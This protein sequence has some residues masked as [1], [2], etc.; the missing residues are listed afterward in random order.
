MRDRPSPGQRRLRAVRRPAHRRARAAVAAAPAAAAPP[1]R[2]GRWVR[3][4]GGRGGGGRGAQLPRR[5]LGGSERSAGGSAGLRGARLRPWRREAAPRRGAGH[6]RGGGARPRPAAPP[7]NPLRP[8]YPRAVLRPGAPGLSESR[9][10]GASPAALSL[11]GAASPGLGGAAPQ[12]PPASPGRGGGG[13]AAGGGSRPPQR[14]GAGRGS[15][16][17]GG[18]VPPAPGA[19]L[20]HYPAPPPESTEPFKT[21]RAL[22]AAGAVRLGKEAPGGRAAAPPAG[23]TPRCSP[24]A[25]RA[26]GPDPGRRLPAQEREVRR[27]RRT[28]TAGGQPVAPERFGGGLSHFG[29]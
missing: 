15:W 4:A 9:R 8:L 13:E 7:G 2:R 1:P 14:Q 16:R 10:G 28:R 20:G 12:A 24:P 19:R 27:G 17:R 22:P 21:G 25:L 3:P 11:P 29:E 26:A 23:L 5:K 6:Q 18:A